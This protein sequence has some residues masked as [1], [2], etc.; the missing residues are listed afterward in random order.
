MDMDPGYW[1]AFDHDDHGIVGFQF[2]DQCRP[3]GIQAEN[4][5]P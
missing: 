5:T 3:T 2:I 1:E 4:V